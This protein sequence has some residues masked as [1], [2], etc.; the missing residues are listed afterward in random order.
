VL[1]L[2]LILDTLGKCKYDT[3]KILPVKWD[4]DNSVRL[5]NCIRNINTAQKSGYD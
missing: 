2:V 3:W 5:Q 1:F 4:F